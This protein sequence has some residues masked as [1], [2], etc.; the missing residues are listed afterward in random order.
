MSALSL[1]MSLKY[2][3]DGRAKRPP[4]YSKQLE[5][6]YSWFRGLLEVSQLGYYD[7]NTHNFSKGLRSG[8]RC[9]NSCY[10]CRNQYS[11]LPCEEDMILLPN[12]MYT[13]G[14]AYHNIVYHSD[15]I[16]RIEWFKLAQ[17]EEY[18]SMSFSETKNKGNLPTWHVLK[19]RFAYKLQ[20][21]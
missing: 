16:P 6:E 7:K 2:D 19:D 5:K 4:K 11:I 3:N 10:T 14:L 1:M 13:N 9:I 17:L 15:E 8:M 12:G 18:I 20:D 21:E